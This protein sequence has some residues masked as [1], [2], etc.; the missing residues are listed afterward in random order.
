MEVEENTYFHGNYHHASMAEAS[1]TSTMYET[2]IWCQRFFL[3]KD[4]CF[5]QAVFSVMVIS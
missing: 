3:H 4:S 5:L 2:I 1:T